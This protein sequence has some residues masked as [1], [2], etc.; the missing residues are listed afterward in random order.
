MYGEWC[1]PLDISND[2][3]CVTGTSTKHCFV[4]YSD[5]EMISEVKMYAMLMMLTRQTQSRKRKFMVV[6]LS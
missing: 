2:L 3:W 5:L 1:I 6:F 4:V